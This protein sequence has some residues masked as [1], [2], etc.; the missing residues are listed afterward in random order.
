MKNKRIIIKENPSHD[1]QHQ[2]LLGRYEENDLPKNIK[3]ISIVLSTI[4]IVRI[5]AFNSNHLFRQAQI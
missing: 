1:Q 2:A 3:T 5:S 4:L